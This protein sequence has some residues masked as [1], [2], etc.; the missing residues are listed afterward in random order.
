MTIA[1]IVRNGE[2]R[3]GKWRVTGA[4]SVIGSNDIDAR[5]LW[6]YST[7][8]L[9]WRTSDNHIIYKSTGHGSVSDQNGVNIALKVLAGYVHHCGGLIPNGG[10]GPAFYFSRAGGAR[11]IESR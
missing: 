1:K 8:M 11:Y 4:E 2:G 5:A 6:H 3:A 10:S 7:V 9:A